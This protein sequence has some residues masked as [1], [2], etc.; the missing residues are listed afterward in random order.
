VKEKL[1]LIEQ[2]KTRFNTNK[3]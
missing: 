3:N 2:I 1:V